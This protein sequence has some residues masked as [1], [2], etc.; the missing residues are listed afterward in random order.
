MNLSKC[1]SLEVI[2]VTGSASQTKVMYP[3]KFVFVVNGKLIKLCE[4][5]LIVKCIIESVLIVKSGNMTGRGKGGSRS[6]P[7]CRTNMG[8]HGAQPL[9]NFPLPCPLVLQELPL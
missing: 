6:N 4:F 1:F 5:Y 8:D 7:E 3:T 2:K 9:E